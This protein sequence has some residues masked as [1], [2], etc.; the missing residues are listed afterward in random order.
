MKNK[1]IIVI[2]TGA[3]AAVVVVSLYHSTTSTPV[4]ATASSMDSPSQTLQPPSLSVQV[5]NGQE[6]REPVNMTAADLEALKVIGSGLRSLENEDARERAKLARLGKVAM[7]SFLKNWNP[8]GKTPQ[9]LKVI[10]GKPKE[11]ES[12]FLLYAFDNGSYASL[13]QF[14]IRDGRVAELLRPKSE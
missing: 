8:I 6:P 7:E 5:A 13:Y 3:A 11:E 12:D 14:V 4:G 2:L 9:D 1:A 10:L